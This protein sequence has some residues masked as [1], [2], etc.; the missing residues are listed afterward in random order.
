MKPTVKESKRSEEV[1]KELRDQGYR[2]YW[3]VVN[4]LTR[5][6]YFT[7][8]QG[9]ALLLL[10]HAHDLKWESWDLYRPVSGS[11]KIADTFAEL[12][13]YSEAVV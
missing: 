9:H 4:D 12:K 5:V 1:R 2:C 11:N 3:D 7:D 8:G 10:E 6:T 13:M